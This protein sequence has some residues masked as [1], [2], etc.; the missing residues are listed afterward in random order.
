ML[1]TWLFW[2]GCIGF[3]AI[4]FIWMW[5]YADKIEKLEQ[6]ENQWKEYIAQLERT[7]PMAAWMWQQQFEEKFRKK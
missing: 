6:E 2:A 3:I 4:S 5:R 7:D 1:V